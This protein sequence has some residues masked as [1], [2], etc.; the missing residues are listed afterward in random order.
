M[1]FSEQ[2]IIT[3]PFEAPRQHYELDGEGQPTGR[4]LSGRRESIQ[5]VPV[6][7]ARRRGASAAQLPL[8]DSISKNALI[9]EI[10]KHVGPWRDL[11]PSQWGV[12]PE[13]QR[14]LLHWRD[15]HRSPEI[16]E[17]AWSE[18]NSTI[19]RPFPKPSSGR[20]CVKVINHFGDEVQKVFEV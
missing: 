9:N 16:D 7:A 2:P 11:P 18:M 10:R 15:P 20:I 1:A 5:F 13:T 12:T 3:S 6:P 19:S 4:L 17:T 14:L 8:F